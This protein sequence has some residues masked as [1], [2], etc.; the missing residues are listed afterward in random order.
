MAQY[1]AQPGD[2]AA[3][4]PVLERLA[5]HAS[6]PGC[7]N[8]RSGG[9]RAL[10][11]RPAEDFGGIDV[12]TL[13]VGG[14]EPARTARRSSR[15]T[16]ATRTIG[17]C[18]ACR[19]TRRSRRDRRSTIDL[20]WTARVPR[21]FARTGRLGDYYFIAQWFPKIGVLEDAGWNCH[22]F[23]AATEFFSDFGTYDVTLTV[24]TGWIV[25]A[26]GQAES[27]TTG[28]GGTSH[29]FVQAD[30]HDFAWTTSPDFLDR[31]ETFERAGPAA[32]RHAPAAAAGTC[33][34]GRSPFRGHARGA[35]V[36]RHL[37]RCLSVRP[38]HHRR[39]G[40]R[41]SIAAS[42]GESTGGMEYPTLFTAGTRWYVP[43]ARHAAGERD[44]ARS[45]PPVLVR[46]GRHQR[47]RTRVDGRGPQ[48]LSRPRACSTRRIPGRF[49]AVE[50]YFGGL[51][52]WSYADVRV[53]ARHRRQPSERVPAGRV[54]RRSSPRR[55][56]STGRAAA[57]AITY[58]KT[59]LWL[60]TLERLLGWPTTQKIL[61]TY[62]S[63][64]AFRHPTPER[65]LRDRERSQR[66]GP[67]LVL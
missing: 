55:R 24:P 51:M 33:R 62:F 36:L 60:A 46:H 3:L 21:T 9:N 54:V 48:H 32:G 31:R 52:A 4:S 53:V 28:A 65:V 1:L 7:A 58:N 57:S 47:V 38:H 39:S 17:R 63:R 16:T 44:R 30:V 50:R 66:A 11:R 6:R 67:D 19:S 8:R 26:T 43:W 14:A 59:A 23:H 22:Q 42:Q 13:A 34:P 5:R 45:R 20:A 61:S 35:E 64:G 2:G 18:C 56:G 40:R 12:T 25:G 27:A 49:V 10:A 41:S 29:R 37:V 15:P